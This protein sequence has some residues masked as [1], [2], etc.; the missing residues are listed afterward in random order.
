MTL[1]PIKSSNY[2]QNLSAI[3]TEQSSSSKTF[4]VFAG[5]AATSAFCIWKLFNQK[6]KAP[7]N[8]SST[9]PS[10][11]SKNETIKTPSQSNSRPNANLESSL[12]VSTRQPIDATLNRQEIDA[13]LDAMLSECTLNHV[14]TQPRES[15]KPQNARHLISKDETDAILEETLSQLF[16]LEEHSTQPFVQINSRAPQSTE[17]LARFFSQGS[18]EDVDMPRQTTEVFLEGTPTD[19]SNPGHVASPSLRKISGVPFP[20]AEI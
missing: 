13:L 17:T 18:S 4:L 6:S 10:T 11:T 9:V 7:K 20:S 15:L 5:L 14:T 12:P 8:S 16:F 2:H 1:Q 19:E 3:K